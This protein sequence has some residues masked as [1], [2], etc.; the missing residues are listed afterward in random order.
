MQKKPELAVITKTPEEMGD[1]IALLFRVDSNVSALA[2]LKVIKGADL[3][4][5][6]RKPEGILITFFSYFDMFK[7]WMRIRDG[8]SIENVMVVPEPQTSSISQADRKRAY[9]AHA[10]GGTRSVSLSGLEDFMTG[11]FLSEE[12]EKFGEIEAL[13]Y[14][15]DRHCCY[16]EFFSFFAAMQF[17]SSIREDSLFEKV[18]VAFGRDMCGAGETDGVISHNRTVYFGS[19]PVDV[20]A[21]EIL[22]VVQGGAVIGLKVIREKKC[23]FVTFFDYVAANAFI[24]YSN[25][26]PPVIRGVQVKI[27]PGKVQPIIPA[28]PIF[29]Y[30]GV[31]RT[32]SLRPTNNIAPATIE[33]VLSKYGEVDRV[34][35]EEEGVFSVAMVNL[36]DAQAA[37]SGLEQ[38]PHWCTALN[39]FAPDTCATPSHHTLLMKVQQ[40]EFAL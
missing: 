23:A 9:L 17:A 7:I 34:Q 39:G 37:Y 32:L 4:A 5:I 35:R 12:A 2:V 36:V 18:R 3:L 26:Y 38:D 33:S 16:I 24:E 30:A 11:E 1:Y 20:T 10:A 14:L 19:L 40:R 22:A 13:K 8:V 31:T 28:I 15:R 29:A 25:L 6:E 21:S 27:G